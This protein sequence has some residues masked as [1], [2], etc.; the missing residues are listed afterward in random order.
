[1]GSLEVSDIDDVVADFNQNAGKN[2]MWDFFRK[3][4]QHHHDGK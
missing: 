2:R 4:R 1:M 3:R